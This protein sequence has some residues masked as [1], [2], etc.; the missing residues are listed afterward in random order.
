MK[1]ITIHD[2][3]ILIDLIELNLLTGFFKLGFEF[4]TTDFVLNEIVK[5]VQKKKIKS[6][7]S[8][9]IIKA[10]NVTEL[11]KLAELQNNHKTLS[12][13]DISVMELSSELKGILC[14]GDKRLKNVA[15]SR[16][17]EV[18]G[19]LWVIESMVEQ[20]VISRM[21]A[22]Q[23]LEKLKNMNSR[24]PNSLINNYIERYK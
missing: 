9:F 15:E 21:K 17:I 20:N 1:T 24:V 19:I 3:N 5:S 11:L 18:H 22:T 10:F 6:F 23:A 2:T 7:E 14:T 8:K 16:G 4:H 12:I 13:E